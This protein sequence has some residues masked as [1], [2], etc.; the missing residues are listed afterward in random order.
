MRR[1]SAPRRAQTPSSGRGGASIRS[2]NRPSSARGRIGA[3]PGWGR[4]GS[5]SKAAAEVP[6]GGR[7]GDPLCPQGIE[8]DLVVASPF[9]VF[10][11]LAAGEEIEGDVEHMVGFVVG[12]M[13][14][15]R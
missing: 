10:D 11:P 14:L 3:R 2:R 7:V 9:D 15:E 13:A 1:M 4:S 5:G 8:V 6:G 12:E